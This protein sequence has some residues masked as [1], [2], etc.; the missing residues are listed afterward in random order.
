MDD[1]RAVDPAEARDLVVRGATLLDVRDD[2]EWSAGRA[3]G[4]IHVVLSDLPDRVDELDRSR[5]VVCVCRVGGR[6]LRAAHFLHEE[7]FEV[8]NLDGGMVAWA[9]GG[10]DLESDSQPPRIV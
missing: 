8:A 6:S 7:G 1:V 5:L 2:S 3:P 10:G 4:A 9:E